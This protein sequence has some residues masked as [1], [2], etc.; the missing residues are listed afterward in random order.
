[1]KGMPL[2]GEKGMS[3][4]A[5]EAGAHVKRSVGGQVQQ[6]MRKDGGEILLHTL[7]AM[8]SRVREILK[9]QGLLGLIRFL[10]RAFVYRRWK[11]ILLCDLVGASRQPI[12]FPNGLVFR[13]WFRHQEM[14][15][16]VRI[17]VH[18]AGGGE[19]LAELEDCDG[20]WVLSTRDGRPAGWG[21]VYFRSRQARVLAL[22]PGAVLLGG[23]F[24]LPEFRG[25]S[26]HRLAVHEIARVLA[27]EGRKEVYAEVHPENIRSLRGVEGAQFAR[28]GDVNLRIIFRRLI[29][30]DSGI[31]WV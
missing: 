2:A 19:F 8:V 21:G 24:V 16:D 27:Q 7:Q 5:R 31:K 15:D 30:G 23:H 3:P 9:A 26:L 28:V 1:M 11:T 17:K 29:V 18:A 13:H 6:Q 12:G 10:F 20:V 14:P 4:V 22:P 25:Q